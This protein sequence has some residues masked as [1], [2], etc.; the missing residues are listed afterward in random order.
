MNKLFN[1]ILLAGMAIVAISCADPENP[2][3]TQMSYGSWDV[4][5]V[6]VND[7]VNPSDV[8]DRFTL[9]KD[10]NFVLVDVNEFVTVGTWAAT[11]AAL[12]L[13][14]SDAT[15]TDFAIISQSFSSMHLVQTIP[16]ANAGTIEIR[17]LMN[18]STSPTYY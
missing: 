10:G 5:Q 18:K 13:T 14:A 3:P 11:D 17:Y 12:T 15:V 1:Y 4:K 7:Q 2:T 6:F 16:T 9:E 8:L